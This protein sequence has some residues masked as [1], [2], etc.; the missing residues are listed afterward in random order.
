MQIQYLDQFNINCW[1]SNTCKKK[2]RGWCTSM[3]KRITC[4]SYIEPSQLFAEQ[5]TRDE[6][7]IDFPRSTT[8]CRNAK[9]FVQNIHRSGKDVIRWNAEESKRDNKKARE[10]VE[11]VE[12]RGKARIRRSREIT[13]L[14]NADWGKFATITKMAKIAC[15]RHGGGR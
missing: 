14:K 6:R 12:R 9:L 8:C 7:R 4:T 13:V 10:N 3:K 15:R 5:W 2:A 11:N 1:A